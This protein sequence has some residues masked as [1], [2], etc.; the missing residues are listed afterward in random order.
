M[1]FLATCHPLLV[2]K[3]A[4]SQCLNLEGQSTLF[5]GSSLVRFTTSSKR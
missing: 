1:R 3:Y 5:K 4:N 2:T